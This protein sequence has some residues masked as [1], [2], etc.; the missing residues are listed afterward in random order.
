MKIGIPHVDP[1][2]GELFV[3]DPPERTEL[4]EAGRERL[5]REKEE[6]IARL[7]RKRKAENAWLEEEAALQNDPHRLVT[8]QHIRGYKTWG[9]GYRG[10]P[11]EIP[12]E[13]VSG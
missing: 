1:A 13:P 7:E 3:P 10:R 2:T 9:N 11:R 6:Q 8:A 12:P 4:T 5:E